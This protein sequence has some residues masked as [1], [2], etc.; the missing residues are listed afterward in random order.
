MA[1]GRIVQS[2]SQRL[3]RRRTS[4]IPLPFFSEELPLDKGAHCR[5]VAASYPKQTF[6]TPTLARG[7]DLTGCPL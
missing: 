1:E 5:T 2:N 7:V 4:D 3:K 6:A